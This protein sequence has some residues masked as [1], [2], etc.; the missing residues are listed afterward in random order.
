VHHQMALQVAETFVSVAIRE[1]FV[2]GHDFSRAVRARKQRWAL[3][4]EGCKLTKLAHYQ[5]FPSL[6]PHHFNTEVRIFSRTLW[7]SFSIC[8]ACRTVS[9]ESVSFEALSVS[10]FS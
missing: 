7:A 6:P 10:A 3:A 9:M 8:S 2:K 1:G 5:R 4:T